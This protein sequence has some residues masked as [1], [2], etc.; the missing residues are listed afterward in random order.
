MMKHR[1][2]ISVRIAAAFF[3]LAFVLCTFF[4]LVS[5][6]SLQVAEKQLVNNRLEKIATQLIDQYQ[7]HLLLS[8]VEDNFY[9]NDEIPPEFRHLRPG[10]HEIHS[11][12][13][14][15]TV[16]IRV[17]GNDVFAI[18]DDTSDFATIEKL[19]RIALGVGFVA[20]LLLAILLGLLSARRIVAPVTALADAIERDDPSSTLPSL[21]SNDEIGMLARAYAK[22]TT[23]LH[24]FL[25]D[26]KLFTGDVSHELRTPLTVI[27]GAAELLKV[28]LAQTPAE[29][30][31]AERIRRVASETS[32][33]VGALLLLSQSPAALQSSQMSMT[34]LLDR[35][36]ERYQPM[37]ADKPVHMIF[38]GGNEEIWIHAS[39]ELVG[40]AV[41]NLIRNACQYTE[42]GVI[43]ITLRSTQMSIEDEGPGLP[44]N[45]RAR[46]FQRFVRGQQHQHVG[47]GLGLAIVKRVVDHLGWQIRH[48][49]TA[50]GGSRFIVQFITEFDDTLISDSANNPG[51]D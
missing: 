13:G 41:G 25:A 50:T 31:V 36:V 14:E 40:I 29:Q 30:E 38:D 44:E 33:R 47:S 4:I 34:H 10:V 20:S 18:A 42:R 1:N 7:R 49:A 21:Q 11:S 39:A 37:L 28:R 51:I 5:N 43:R 23:Q 48:E 46:L 17:I 35:E 3:L 32:E 16:C 26:E 9:V 8:A 24:G 27:L 12:A 45:V 15:M 6:L 22:R 2:S 19:T